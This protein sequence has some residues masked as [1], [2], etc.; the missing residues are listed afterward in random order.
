MQGSAI[1]LYRWANV[2]SC[3]CVCVG[4]KVVAVLIVYGSLAGSSVDLTPM[5]A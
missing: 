1:G 5:G 4:A 3:V 2:V